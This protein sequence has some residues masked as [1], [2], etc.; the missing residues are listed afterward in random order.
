[1]KISESSA[2]S[3]GVTLEIAR[4]RHGFRHCRSAV[5]IIGTVSEL[6]IE[7]S[8]TRFFSS[9]SVLG[10]PRSDPMG[11]RFKMHYRSLNTEPEAA[12]RMR[13][14]TDDAPSISASAFY[15]RF[16]NAL[17]SSRLVSARPSSARAHS[18]TDRIARRNGNVVNRYILVLQLWNPRRIVTLVAHVVRPILDLYVRWNTFWHWCNIQTD[19]RNIGLTCVTYYSSMLPT[20]LLVWY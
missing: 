1:M 12:R 16:G 11:G 7:E 19:V 6:I 14:A 9:I 15:G 10:Q 13:M 17:V 2:V 18:A 3:A 20:W 5:T 4:R 8:R